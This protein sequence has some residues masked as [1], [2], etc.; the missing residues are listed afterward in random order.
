MICIYLPSFSIEELFQCF[1]VIFK[2]SAT[3]L[4]VTSTLEMQV[5]L[6]LLSVSDEE[7]NF[8]LSIVSHDFQRASWFLGWKLSGWSLRT[9]WK[10]KSKSE[11]IVHLQKKVAKKEQ[12]QLFVEKNWGRGGGGGV[13]S[14]VST[15]L[16]YKFQSWRVY[17]LNLAMRDK[18]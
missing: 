2:H 4:N 15:F 5:F 17:R 6:L 14:P 7:S 12:N 11:I 1:I 13:P 18:M 3:S 9:C 10:S 16:R 8:I